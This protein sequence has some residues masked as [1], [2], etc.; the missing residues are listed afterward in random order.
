M[1]NIIKEVAGQV[2]E[3]DNPKIIDILQDQPQLFVKVVG[4]TLRSLREIEQ[5]IIGE[6][7]TGSA[8]KGQPH[9][10]MVVPNSGKS[11]V[12]GNK[13][14]PPMTP[15][16]PV[17]PLRPEIDFHTPPRSSPKV[18]NQCGIEQVSEYLHHWAREGTAFLSH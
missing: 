3:L 9:Q 12:K 5:S 15:D 2:M 13:R 7:T 14:M 16:Y 11:F 10:H 1:E 18:Q 4:A 8:G 6:P 17:T